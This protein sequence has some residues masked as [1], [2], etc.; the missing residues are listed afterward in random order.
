MN[1]DFVYITEMLDATALDTLKITNTGKCVLS[2]VHANSV[3]D[4][5]VRLMDMT[6]MPQDRIIQTLHSV[7]YQELVRDDSK[8]FVYPFIC[9]D[10]EYF[11][12]SGDA[13]SVYP[14]R[15]GEPWNSL[16]LLVFSDALQD[17]RA[18]TLCE[19]IFGREYVENI[20]GEDAPNI[21]FKNYPRSA[22]YILETREKINAAIKYGTDCNNAQN[23][24]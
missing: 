13:F 12:P 14:G 3:G 16:R 21:T 11:T 4:T 18:L 19:R 20:I 1:P 7:V 5:I 24:L 6:G 22:D 15:N 9:T 23:V 10:G 17:I 2:T 8:D